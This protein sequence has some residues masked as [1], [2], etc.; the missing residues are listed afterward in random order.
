VVVLAAVLRVARDRERCK[1]LPCRSRNRPPRND[2]GPEHKET[3][4]DERLTA[5]SAADHGPRRT[6]VCLSCTLSRGY[7]DSVPR[8]LLGNVVPPTKDFP[9]PD[10]DHS[11]ARWPPWCPRFRSYVLIRECQTGRRTGQNQDLDRWLVL[12]RACGVVHPIL[13]WARKHLIARISGCS[14]NPATPWGELL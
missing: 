9:G 10:I 4:S 3:G 12:S 14:S 7:G 2:T 11:V 13:A 5:Q 1:R 6:N 8:R